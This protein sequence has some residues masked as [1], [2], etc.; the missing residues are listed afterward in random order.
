MKLMNDL[1]NSYDW[2]INRQLSGSGNRGKTI[3]SY[4]F[5]EYMVVG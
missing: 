4:F 1:P 3:L 5:N 2:D